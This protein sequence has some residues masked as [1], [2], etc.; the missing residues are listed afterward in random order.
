MKNLMLISFLFLAHAVGFAQIGVNTVEPESTFDIKAKNS[1]GNSTIAEGILIPRVD[2]EKAQSMTGI[3]TST[4]IY[5]NDVTTGTLSGTAVNIDAVGY[6]KFDENLWTKFDTDHDM[7][8]IDGAL[9]GNRIVDEGA[10]R[11]AFNATGTNAFS[12]NQKNLSIDA[13]NNRVGIGTSTPSHSLDIE[14][15]MRL[16][17]SVAGN[18][19]GWA[20]YARP[21]HVDKDNG[22][23][24][25]P[26]RGF[27][28][29]VGGYRPGRNFNLTVLPNTNTIARV[30]FVCYVDAS[31]NSN[32]EIAQSYTYGEFTIIGTGPSNPIKFV[33][34]NIKDA[35]GNSK[36]L[37]TSNGTSIG[38]DNYVQGTTTLRLNQ[39]TGVFSIANQY[40]VMSYFF[41]ILGGT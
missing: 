29:V 34:I 37:L 16:S 38:W 27:T 36:P 28:S 11:L 22:Q 24:T 39:T 3:K 35:Y 15:T 9:L 1:T 7:Y 32:N 30:R 33:D 5:V 2:R 25:I 20:Y 23:M 26:P 4:M 31:N 12:V 10:N 40:D 21:L 14:G 41:E 8:S 6:Y 17:Q 13:A 19:P 18:I